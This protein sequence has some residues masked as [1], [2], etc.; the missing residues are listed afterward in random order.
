MFDNRAALV[1]TAF[2]ADRVCWDSVAAL[3]AVPDL[4]FL[5]PI[6]TASFA[7]TAV[8]MFAFW[9]SHRCDPF[10][11]FKGSIEPRILENRQ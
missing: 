4:A 7:G 3:G 1:V 5:D 8:R 9:D 11:V 2:R 10:G 6:M